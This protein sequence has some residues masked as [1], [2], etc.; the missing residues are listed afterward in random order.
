MYKCFLNAWN[1]RS[2]KIIPKKLVFAIQMSPNHLIAIY[3]QDLNSH[4]IISSQS[5]LDSTQILGYCP[6]FQ[7]KQT[8][9]FVIHW[10]RIEHLVVTLPKHQTRLVQEPTAL[11]PII[12]RCWPR[13][14]A[15]FSCGYYRKTHTHTKITKATLWDSIPYTLWILTSK[16]INRVNGR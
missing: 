8:K 15:C 16:A 5:S 6:Y 3:F 10:T 4:K 7:Y 9:A 1:S 12:G 14:R 13:V 2:S 11:V